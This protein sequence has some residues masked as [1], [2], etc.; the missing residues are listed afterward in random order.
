[1]EEQESV[2]DFYLKEAKRIKNTFRA[3]ESDDDEE[4]IG[5]DEG[6]KLEAI[7]LGMSEGSKDPKVEA[8]IKKMK[9]TELKE[10]ENAEEIGGKE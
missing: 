2:T 4:D 8:M 6:D 5:T 10:A 7:Y 1:M 9:E 3:K